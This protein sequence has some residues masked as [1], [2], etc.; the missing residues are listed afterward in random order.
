MLLLITS[1][2]TV[3]SSLLYGFT[4]EAGTKIL[5]KT[6]FVSGLNVSENMAAESRFALDWFVEFLGLAILEAGFELCFAVFGLNS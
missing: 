4:F 5:S 6:F 1:F 2:F 3:K